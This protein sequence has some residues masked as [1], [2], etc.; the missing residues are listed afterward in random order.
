MTIVVDPQDGS[1]SR[2]KPR[3]RRGPEWSAV[4]MVGAGSGSQAKVVAAPSMASPATLP[5]GV[6]DQLALMTAELTRMSQELREM[7]R[8]NAMLRQQ[9]E[10]LR[11]L[12]Q[13]DPYSLQ[14]STTTAESSTTVQQPPPARTRGVGDL[15]PAHEVQKPGD[16]DAVM[17]S[18]STEADPKRARRS[19]QGVLMGA[20]TERLDTS[21]AGAPPCSDP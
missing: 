12:Q 7:R 8:E 13:H 11:G 14:P 1:G 15:S 4:D 5:A 3:N 18:P 20:D 21:A 6:N 19:L 9:V 10:K 2:R 17:A 16:D